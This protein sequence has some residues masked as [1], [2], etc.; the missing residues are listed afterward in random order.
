MNINWQ[1]RF[2][3]PHFIY[4]I[5][6]AFFMPILAYFGLTYADL[7]SWSSLLDTLFKAVSNPYVCGLVLVSVW[8]AIQDPTTLGISDSKSVLSS[9]EP[10]K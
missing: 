1:V 6:M 9:K 2:K 4:Q 5:F 3:N 7:T 10:D 8:N